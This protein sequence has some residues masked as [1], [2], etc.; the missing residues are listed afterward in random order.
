LENLVEEDLVEKVEDLVED[1]VEKHVENVE[2]AE[3]V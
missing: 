1:L 3:V 2:N